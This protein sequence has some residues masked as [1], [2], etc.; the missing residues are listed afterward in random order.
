MTTQNSTA[1]LIDWEC[2]LF[3]VS[4]PVLTSPKLLLSRTLKAYQKCSVIK[5]ALTEE[6]YRLGAVDHAS[7]MHILYKPHHSFPCHRKKN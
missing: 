4:H 2:W 7:A 1:Q 5:M 3:Y 6:P